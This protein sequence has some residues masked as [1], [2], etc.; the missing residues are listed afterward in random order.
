C[1]V[2]R[3]IVAAPSYLSRYGRPGHPR[4]LTAHHCLGYAYRSRQDV[5]RFSNG[6]DEETI[7]PSGPLRVTNADALVP[8]VLDGLAIA[9]LPEFIAS[10][11]LADGRLE[12]ILTDWPLPIGG[13]YFVTPSARSRPAKVAALVD[14]FV[15]RLSEPEWRWPRG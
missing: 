1:G 5:W 13:L 14:F 9:E 10:E 6:G 3:F 11:Y 15:E 8:T 4:D 7:T 2:A 12:S